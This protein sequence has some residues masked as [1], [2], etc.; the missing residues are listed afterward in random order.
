MS[1]CTYVEIEG[2]DVLDELSDNDLLEE[3]KNRNLGTETAGFPADVAEE[4]AIAARAGDAWRVLDLVLA[5]L[6]PLKSPCKATPYE[7]LERDPVSG[8]PVIQ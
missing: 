4:M 2:D 1:I 5:T 6:P 8:R 3:L 7:A